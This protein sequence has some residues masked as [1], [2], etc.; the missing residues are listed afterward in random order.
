MFDSF[1]DI[2]WYLDL[3][4]HPQMNLLFYDDGMER[5]KNGNFYFGSGGAGFG[6]GGD[7]L[8]YEINLFGNVL[9]TWEMPGYSFHHEVLEKPNGNFLVTVNKM[10]E[11]TVEDHIIEINRD[12]K[13]VI[14]E[15]DL[16]LSLDN[17]RTALTKS[18][19]DWIHVNAITYDDTDETILVSGRTQGLIKLTSANEV[20]WI[21]GTHKDWGTSGNGEDLTQFLLTP[22]DKGGQPILT[23]AVLEGDENHPDFEW[24]WYQ[25]APLIMPDGNIMLFDNGDQ[26]NYSDTSSYSRAVTYTVNNSKKTIQQVWQYGKERGAE[27]YSTIVSDVDYLEQLDH[28]IFSPGAVTRNNGFYGKSIEV[29]VTSGA[30][31]FEATITPPNPFFGIITFH[32]TERLPLY[33][34]EL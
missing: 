29:E 20:V 14:N 24:N 22:L 16:N 1:G 8:I 4:T 15:W 17:T 5:L 25:H 19:S 18:E 31:L 33:P 2:R 28:V 6:A 9:N 32:R 23:A 13:E 7:N 11:S 27:T 26:R 10:G 3:S 12:T 21:M 30:V 34:P